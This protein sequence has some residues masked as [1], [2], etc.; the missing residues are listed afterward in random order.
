MRFFGYLSIAACCA[1]VSAAPAPSNHR[2]HEKRNGHPHEWTKRSRAH[3]QKILPI[4]IGL[5]QRNLHLA[6]EFLID[7]SDPASPNFGKHWSA[8]KIANTFAPS[9]EATDTVTNWLLDSGI[10]ASRLTYS[11]GRNWI[12]FNG[13][14]EEAERLFNTEYHFFEHKQTGGFRIACD[15]YHLPMHVSSHVDFAM[16]TIQLDGL[17]PIANLDPALTAPSPLT[18]LTGTKNCNEL[19]TIDCL[20]A[21]YN[22]G[23]LNSSLPGNEMGIAEW[24]DY[25]YDPDLVPFFQNWTSPQI[26]SNTLPE[27]I[28]IDGGKASNATQAEAGNVIESALDFQTAYSIIWPQKLRLYQVGDGVN[29][30]SVGT[31]NIFLDALDA[32]YCTYKGGDAP[33]VDPAYPDP[34]L[35]GYTGPLQCGGA[36]VSNVFSFSYNQIEAAL[37]EFY[38]R[39][40][41]HEWMK[42]GLQG[43]SVLFASGDSGVANRYNA[44]YENSCLNTDEPYVDVNGTRFSPSFPCNCPYVTVVGATQLATSS[45]TGSEVAVAKPNLT[46]HK[47]DYY[48]GGGF[49]NIFTV[50]DYQKSAV[51]GY[52][53]S[54]PPPYNAKTYN[55]SGTSRAYPDVS[56]LGLNI[57]TV[58]LNQ[59][60]GVGGTSASTPI[61]ASLVNLLNEERMQKGKGPVGFLNPIFYAHPEAFNDITEGANPGCGTEGFAARPGWDPVTGLGTPRYEKLRE[62]FLGLP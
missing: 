54:Y 22:F 38:Q 46:N 17:R 45:I 61:V 29:V 32:S 21:L 23:F 16:P 34:N 52:L 44:G 11:T 47:L 19:I 18:G 8:E 31:F 33:Y 56:A 41:C 42:L 4:R 10:D 20:R 9:R 51:S 50:P 37:P 40:Q 39:R 48:S 59:T 30:D 43:V 12:Q 7:V 26:P 62:I 53:S 60:Y 28:S 15:E 24:A 25:L 55:N 27:F 3:G 58:Y 49:S 6:D 14:V 57:T 2:L 36:P 13:T 1:L 5:Q 35:G